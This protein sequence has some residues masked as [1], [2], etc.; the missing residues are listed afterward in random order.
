MNSN[1]LSSSPSPRLAREDDEEKKKKEEEETEK[2][3]DMMV[4]DGASAN[5][6][7]Q[8][9]VIVTECEQHDDDDEEEEDGGGGGRRRCYLNEPFLRPLLGQNQELRGEEPT[10][11][12]VLNRGRETFDQP[13]S[14]GSSSSS[15]SISAGS[16]NTSTRQEYGAG[17]VSQLLLGLDPS[18]DPALALWAG[19]RVQAEAA[20]RTSRRSIREFLKNRDRQWK[21]KEGSTAMD[22]NKKQE[23]PA[24]PTDLRASRSYGFEDTLRL[25]VGSQA[26]NSNNNNAT[27]DHHRHPFR[28]ANYG[29]TA[30]DVC[31]ILVH[32]PSV[33]LMRPLRST[34][35]RVDGDG[36]GGSGG[37]ETLEETLDRVMT[38]LAGT[39]GLRRY[40]ARKVLRSCPG[41]LTVRGSKRAEQTIQMLTTTLKVSACSI[42]R[43]K[44]GLPRLLT[45]I[46]SDWFRLVAFLAS[47]AVR[48][49]VSQIGPLLRQAKSRELL[50]RVAPAPVRSSCLYDQDHHHHHHDDDDDDDDDDCYDS[51]LQEGT[52]SADSG[53]SPWWSSSYSYRRS[54][55]NAAYRNMTRTAWTLRNELGT[56]DLG[57]VIASY[58]SV[59]LL[60]AQAQVLPVARFLM[61]ELGVWEDDLPRVLQLYPAL[62]GVD[63]DKMRAVST[64]LTQELDVDPQN[65]AVVFRSFPSLLTLSVDD[66]MRPVVQFLKEDIGIANVGRFVGRLPPVLGYSVDR[67]L[68]PK[69]EFFRQTLGGNNARL[70]VTRF[71]ACFSYPLERIIRTRFEYLKQV[72]RIPVPLVSLDQVLRYGDRDFSLKVARDADG[73]AAFAAFVERRAK[74]KTKATMTTTMT[75]KA[76]RTTSSA[77]QQRQHL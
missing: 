64:Y 65:L 47:D 56:A 2:E 6:V 43:D 3:E 32:T 58:P 49:P 39:L 8:A 55:I 67:E 22:M 4:V 71:P 61:D 52:A 54:K 11:Q 62:L 23:A 51:E 35:D 57:R 75:T 31:E 73:G 44:P 1:G 41:L 7:R 60:D 63:L 13:I 24:F 77:P 70:E 48:M 74:D 37:G 33:A 66:D 69:W 34:P 50:D 72:K 68:R 18:L 19:E 38:L 21:Q 9:T 42:A 59:L 25:L 17:R 53:Y 36:G 40:D 27:A 10:P 29:L 28:S 15:V 12:K 16:T 5:A 46:P 20:F 76:R 30:R 14:S 45:R 26:P